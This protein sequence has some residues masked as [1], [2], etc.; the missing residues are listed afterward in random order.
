MLLQISRSAFYPK[1]KAIKNNDDSNS[2]VG[3]PIS[4]FS[5]GTSNCI[6]DDS[7]IETLL[8]EA[9]EKTPF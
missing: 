4:G 2:K 6:V 9:C 5:Y 3:R 1:K 7:V 8:H